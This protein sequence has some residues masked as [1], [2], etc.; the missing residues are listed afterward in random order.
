[1][2][3]K[4]LAAV[5]RGRESDFNFPKTVLLGWLNDARRDLFFCA[6]KN[7]LVEFPHALQIRW[8]QRKAKLVGFKEGWK[9]YR[10]NPSE[11]ISTTL[12][13]WT[14]PIMSLEQKESL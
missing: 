14:K 9:T 4:A 8:Q 11:T 10:Q 12:P 7:R 13:V 1:G 6:R 5:W 3:A 2:E